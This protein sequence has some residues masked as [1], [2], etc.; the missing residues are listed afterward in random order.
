ML[1]RE[2]Q[3]KNAAA[4][5]FLNEFKDLMIIIL[6]EIGLLHLIKKE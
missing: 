3:L 6:L 2:E 1:M 5:K 4:S